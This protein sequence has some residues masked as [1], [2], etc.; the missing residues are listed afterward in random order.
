MGAVAAGS[1]GPRTGSDGRQGQVGWRPIVS[2]SGNGPSQ[3]D[4]F[5]I[6][7]GEW[8]IKWTARSRKSHYP[9]KLRVTVHSAISGRPLMVAIDHQGPGRDVTYINED[10]R[11][12]HLVI[13]SS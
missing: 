12:Y 3:S 4:S 13:E 5:N 1:C 11:L 10:P 8:R 2:L 7:T 9:E 6:E